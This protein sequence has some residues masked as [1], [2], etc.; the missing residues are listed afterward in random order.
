MNYKIEDN[1]YNSVIKSSMNSKY[2]C[3]I[4]FRNK[5]ISIGIN[6]Y[7][8]CKYEKQFDSKYECN[9]FSIHAEKDAIRKVKNK[10]ILQYCKIYIVK[11]KEGKLEQ[12]IPCPMCYNLLKKYNINKIF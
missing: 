5:I 6:K 9:K 10:N 7:K 3:A 4:L 12:G 2:A 1:L 8:T 11:I